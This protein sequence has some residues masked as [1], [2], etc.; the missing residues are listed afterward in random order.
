MYIRNDK[1]NKIHLNYIV[2]MSSQLIKS[3]KSQ[4]VNIGEEI[5]NIFQK[6]VNDDYKITYIYTGYTTNKLICDPNGE[7]TEWV[8]QNKYSGKITRYEQ[9]SALIGDK[10]FTMEN[11][12]DMKIE[13]QLLFEKEQKLKEK[14]KELNELAS[15]EV[16]YERQLMTLEFIL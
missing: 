10:L 12:N 15:L 1:N 7:Y 2:V 6:Y 4:Y 13:F 11:I 14:I 16:N 8:V 3:L 5:Q 9:K